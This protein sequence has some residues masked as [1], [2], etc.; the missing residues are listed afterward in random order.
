MDNVE[1]EQTQVEGDGEKV[2]LAGGSLNDSTLD[3]DN[4]VF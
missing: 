3:L 4:I 2:D 1:V